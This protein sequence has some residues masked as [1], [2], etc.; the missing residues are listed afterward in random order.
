MKRVVICGNMNIGEIEGL[1]QNVY[2]VFK[3]DAIVFFGEKQIGSI[4]FFLHLI[5]DVV[6]DILAVY[7]ARIAG[8]FD[9][10]LD[11]FVKFFHRCNSIIGISQSFYTH[12]IE[13]KC[14]ISIQNL[15]RSGKTKQ[16]LLFTYTGINKR[17]LL[18]THT[19][20]VMEFAVASHFNTVNTCCHH[21]F[22]RHFRFQKCLPVNRNKRGSKMKNRSA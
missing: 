6:V 15:H 16:G 4:F 12:C 7:L 14:V 3:Y 21:V 22:L 17:G 19:C 13:F 5:A 11:C 1:I 10:V 9:L 2:L 20:P 18:Y 8:S